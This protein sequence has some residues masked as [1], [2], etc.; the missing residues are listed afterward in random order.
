MLLLKHP[1]LSVSYFKVLSLLFNLL[2]VAPYVGVGGTGGV[3][4]PPPLKVQI[5]LPPLVNPIM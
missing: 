1:L 4:S 3:T 2:Q 5:P